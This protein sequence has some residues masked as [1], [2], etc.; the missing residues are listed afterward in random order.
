MT[1][2][3]GKVIIEARSCGKFLCDIWAGQCGNGNK[4]RFLCDIW[5][6]QGGNGSK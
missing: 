3:L 5:A 1:S 4:L 2:V 6:G